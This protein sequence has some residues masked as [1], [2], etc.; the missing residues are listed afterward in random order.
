MSCI[1]TT[2]QVRQHS[3]GGGGH[4]ITQTFLIG[5]AKISQRVVAEG[6]ALLDL[7]DQ[8]CPCIYSTAVTSS[9]GQLS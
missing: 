6:S 9:D 1:F 2:T 7:S 8:L 5:F 4:P 3:I